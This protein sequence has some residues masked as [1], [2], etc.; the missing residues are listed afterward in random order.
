MS[1]TY[2]VS[3]EARMRSVKG[4]PFRAVQADIESYKG[5]FFIWGGLIARASVTRRGTELEVVQ[6][7]VN[8]YG[9]IT[10]PDVSE[11]RFLVRSKK[12]LDPLIFDK[13]RYITVAGKLVGG[14]KRRLGD[15][16]YVYPVL[17]PLEIHLWKEEVY[18]PYY[19][20]PQWYYDPY[21]YPYYGPYYYPYGPPWW[22]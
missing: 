2:A 11:G 12:L 13:G 15:G 7:P 4:V 14:V 17:E 19:D 8:Q 5:K 3:K 18:Y 6:N 22:W 10:D 20:Y 1:C 21:F 16:E 9:S